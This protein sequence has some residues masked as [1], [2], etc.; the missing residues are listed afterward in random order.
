MTT[1]HVIDGLKPSRGS[2]YPNDALEV[3]EILKKYHNEDPVIVPVGGGTRLQVGALLPSYDYALDLSK[4][5]GIVTHNAE[6]LTCIV[7]SGITLGHLQNVLKERGQFLAIDT[8]LP[9]TA[10]VGG[11]LAS[12]APG[13]LR[14]QL[15]HMRDMVI[16]MQVVLASG[17]ITKSGGAVVKNVSG[18]DMA[19]LH[20]GGY[21]T[22]GVIS[23]V[24]FKL[25]PL[26]RKEGAVVVGFPSINELNN[27]SEKVYDSHVMPLSLVGINSSMAKNLNIDVRGSK[28]LAMVRL[29]GRAKAYD[30]QIR[31]TREIYDDLE[32]TS[33]EV[34]EGD[35][36]G[37]VWANLRDFVGYDLPSA[38]SGR[39][40]S[41][42]SRLNSLAIELIKYFESIDAEVSIVVQPGFGT[43]EFHL[44]Q[45]SGFCEE[46]SFGMMGEIN[47]IVKNN[48]SHINYEDL[49]SNLKRGFNMWGH[50]NDGSQTIMTSLRET[51]DPT[52][53][54]N[55]GR[56]IVDMDIS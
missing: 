42:P 23:E 5:N 15:A 3:S 2:F 54:L 22:L 51:Y 8:P 32:S 53:I 18:Y 7:Q 33:F 13:Y 31:I 26:P 37:L 35:I 6:D 46:E 48:D 12:N 9:E 29:G 36:C 4:M 1:K 55:R 49:P 56:Y 41:T 40:F 30:R 38:V 27:F 34:I 50:I 20:I 16:G 45:L 19:R 52:R 43:M 17:T 39:I 14:W 11:T 44:N 24:S 10:T 25:T 21:G 28:Y 47:M